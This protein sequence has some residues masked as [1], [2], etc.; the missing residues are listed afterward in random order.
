[1]LSLFPSLF[2]YGLVAPLI[3][4]IVLGA[5][6]I[7]FGYRKIIK[8][9]DSSGSNTPTYG[10][11]EIV[12]GAFLIVGFF[13]QLAALLNAIILVIKLGFKLKQ[14][15]LLNDGVNYYIILLAMAI[16]L[17]FSGP[18]YFAFDLPL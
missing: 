3:I 15:K 17:L 5:T 16:S 18:G 9:G 11:M 8:K 10:V 4:R 14:G 6:L 12:L 7:D 2:T 1:M 13:T